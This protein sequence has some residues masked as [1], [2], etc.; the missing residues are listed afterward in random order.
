MEEFKKACLPELGGLAPDFEAVTTFGKIRLSEFGKGCWVVLFSH[1]SDFTPVCTTEMMAFAGSY[2]LFRDRNVKLLGLSVDS[3]HS[4]LGWVS[5][6][7]ETTDVEIQFPII[8]DADMRI[9]KLYGMIS[10]SASQ[11]N[12]VRAVFIIDPRRCIRLIQYYPMTVGRNIMEIIRAIDALQYVDEH[13]TP[14]P[15]NW[16]PGTPTVLSAPNTYEE[17]KRRGKT[18][19]GVNCVDWYLCFSESTGN[20]NN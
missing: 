3:L 1:P 20:E 15:A 10:D 4:H 19:V 2:D 12:T 11:T 13:K 14:T 8:A 5:R 7:Y 6:I 17:L 16:I 18:A 9:S